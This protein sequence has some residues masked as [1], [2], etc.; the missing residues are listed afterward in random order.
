[1]ASRC[2]RPLIFAA[3]RSIAISA[4]LFLARRRDTGSSSE[5]TTR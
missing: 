3:C 4:G 5:W 1:M 2:A